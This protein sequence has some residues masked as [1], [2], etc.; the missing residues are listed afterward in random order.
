M[1]RLFSRISK[2]LDPIADCFKEH[3]ESEGMKLVKQVAEAAEAK[4]EKDAGGKGWGCDAGLHWWCC[5]CG[6][7]FWGGGMELA[8]EAAEAMKERLRRW[9]QLQQAVHII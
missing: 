5:G 8:T 3:V 1:Y 9:V 6:C 4:K 7:V 2:G